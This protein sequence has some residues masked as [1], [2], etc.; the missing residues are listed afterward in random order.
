MLLYLIN[1]VINQSF[2]PGYG[3]WED[4]LTFRCMFVFIKSLNSIGLSITL[5]N[6]IGM[7]TDH[8]IAITKPLHYPVIMTRKRVC[9]GIASMWFIAIVAGLSDYFTGIRYLGSLTL[10]YN[11]CEIVW[12]TPF[13]EEYILFGFA[14][15]CLSSMT[16]MY[17]IIY[18]RVRN[19]NRPTS[20]P[21]ATDSNNSG[22]N[23]RRDRKALVTTSLIV[24]TFIFCWLPTCVYQLT[25][26]TIVHINQDL[27]NAYASTLR[28]A[29]QFLYDLLL[30][31]CIADPI[32]YAVRINEIRLGY[33][34]LCC[35]KEQVM[36]QNDSSSYS[37]RTTLS[38]QHGVLLPR[39]HNLSQKSSQSRL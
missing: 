23:R 39:L 32:I 38:S 27:L 6:L 5:L 9:I 15:V 14:F 13:Q 2:Q 11:Y 20:G 31:N 19:R 17:A 36:I 21:S 16:V 24:G 3:P 34:R 4:R 25:L 28:Y 12:L 1:K 7:A 29:D 8:F 10:Y 35:R 26:I 30:V 33:R 37:F 18:H 22:D